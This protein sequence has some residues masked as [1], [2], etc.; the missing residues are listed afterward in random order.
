MAERLLKMK[1]IQANAMIHEVLDFGHT[2]DP[3]GSMTG[4][5]LGGPGAGHTNKPQT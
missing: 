5:V 3:D 2:F 1:R 4:K